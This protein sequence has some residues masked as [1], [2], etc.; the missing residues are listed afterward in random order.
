M[1]QGFASMLFSNLSE[2]QMRI[3][4]VSGKTGQV[5][6]VKVL[7]LRDFQVELWDHINEAMLPETTTNNF[8]LLQ[9]I[10]KKS[11]SET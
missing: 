4:F 9:Q 7:E 8:Y 6:P 3:T 10:I 2:E 11:I 1:N 5:N